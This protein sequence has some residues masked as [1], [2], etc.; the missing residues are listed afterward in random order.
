MLTEGLVIYL[1][2]SAVAE[3]GRALLGCSPVSSWV[4]DFNSPRIQAELAKSMRHT[5]ANAPF[6]FA[7]PNGLAFFEAL[8]WKPRV[9][10]SLFREGVRFKRVP[11]LMRPFALFPEPNPRHLGKERWSAVVRFDRG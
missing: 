2:P 8:G 11:L 9:V 1:E 3:L 7:P 4:V 10:R 6:R 5:L